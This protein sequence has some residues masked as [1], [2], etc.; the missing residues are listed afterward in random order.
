MNYLGP[1]LAELNDETL[2]GD[3]NIEDIILPDETAYLLA[4]HPALHQ[5]H[6]SNSNLLS[7]SSVPPQQL[8]Q[9]QVQQQQQNSNSMHSPG[10]S[11]GNDVL[12]D[13][14]SAVVRIF[15]VCNRHRPSLTSMFCLNF[16][17][18]SFTWFL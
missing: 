10:I 14:Q 18:K 5:F 9:V 11:I 12:Y 8:L 1:T 16:L 3:L 15:V 13:E 4:N 17:G 7:T 6:T 2:L